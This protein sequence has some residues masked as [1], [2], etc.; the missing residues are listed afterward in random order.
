MPRE[1]ATEMHRSFAALTMTV[2]KVSGEL[3]K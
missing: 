3:L 1:R 2:V